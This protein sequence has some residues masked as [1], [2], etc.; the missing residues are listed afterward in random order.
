MRFTIQELGKGADPVVVTVRQTRSA[1]SAFTVFGAY[2][3]IVA[4]KGGRYRLL[5]WRRTAEGPD[6]PIIIAE[7][8]GSGRGSE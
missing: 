5:E 3:T 6:F 1:I 2:A 8:F 7:V 4:F